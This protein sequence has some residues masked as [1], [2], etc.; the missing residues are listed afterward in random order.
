V[1]DDVRDFAPAWVPERHLPS[2]W[3]CAGGSNLAS[4]WTPL[5]GP[6]AAADVTR[7]K[8]GGGPGSMADIETQPMV[9]R[10]DGTTARAM[11]DRVVV[12][13]SQGREM[14]VIAVKATGAPILLGDNEPVIATGSV[15]RRGD[16][17]AGPLPEPLAT[18]PAADRDGYAYAVGGEYVLGLGPEG[19]SMRLAVPGLAQV[20]PTV[21]RSGDIYVA[22]AEAIWKIARGATALPEAPFAKL[23]SAPS[24]QIICDGEGRLY[25]ATASGRL[26]AFSADGSKL[27]EKDLGSPATDMALVRNNALFVGC[28]NTALWRIAR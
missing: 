6:G 25:C 5:A 27:F 9:K 21:T 3:P 13:D 7:V 19:E 4:G 11:D 22:T 1:A 8:T 15:L 2:P 20:R 28:K 14:K 10:P 23:D 12:A 26:T 24:C 16:K 18:G 17:V